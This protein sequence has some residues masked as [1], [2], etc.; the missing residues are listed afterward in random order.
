MRRINR[1]INELYVSKK[2]TLI[3]PYRKK[4]R[5]VVFMVT[6]YSGTEMRL[7]FELRAIKHPCDIPNMQTIHMK[8]TN[9]Y[10]TKKLLK[11]NKKQN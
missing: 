7:E 5:E 11:K 1:K 9:E 2:V 6:S 3:V 8:V 10:P 4:M